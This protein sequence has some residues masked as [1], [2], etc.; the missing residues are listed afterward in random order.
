MFPYIFYIPTFCMSSYIW[1]VFLHFVH[2]LNFLHGLLHSLHVY[3]FRFTLYISPYILYKLPYILYIFILDIFLYIS[4]MSPYVFLH[5]VSFPIFCT[6][7]Y[8]LYV[9]LHFVCFPTFCTL[10]TCFVHIFLYFVHAS[11]HFNHTLFNIITLCQKVYLDLSLL[12]TTLQFYTYRMHIHHCFA[13]NSPAD[14]NRDSPSSPIVGQ[15]ESGPMYLRRVP[16]M[17]VNPMMT[18]KREATKIAPCT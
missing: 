14:L 17:P 2:S 18:S 13:A 5:F 11:L 16:T 3:M 6:S 12:F 8:I 9:L 1:H 15:M 10:P 4:Y 7:S